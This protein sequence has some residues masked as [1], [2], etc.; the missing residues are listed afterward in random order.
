LFLHP[1]P[2]RW[3]YFASPAKKLQFIVVS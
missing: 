1:L 2:G 3:F